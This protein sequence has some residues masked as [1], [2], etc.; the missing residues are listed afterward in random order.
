[1]P[2]KLLEPMKHEF[3]SR[4]PEKDVDTGCVSK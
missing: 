4:E 1:M 3:P 2:G